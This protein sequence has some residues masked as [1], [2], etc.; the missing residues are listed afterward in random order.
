MKTHKIFAVIAVVCLS[1]RAFAIEGLTISIPAT[2]VVLSW[3]SDPSETYIIQYRHTLDTTD[4]WA[5][6]ADYYPADNSTNITFFM[7]T[8]IDFGV[9][10]SGGSSG[11]S[12]MFSSM[13]SSSSEALTWEQILA[14]LMPPTLTGRN[15]TSRQNF[16]DSPVPMDAG[17]GGD[18][19]SGITGTGFYRVVRDGVHIFGLTNGAVVSGTL[20]FPIE[21]ALGST[22][23]IAGVVF[24]DNN[25]TPITGATANGDGNYWTLNWET[26]KTFNGSYNIYAEIDFASDSPAVSVPISVT[27][28]NIISFPNYFSQIFGSQMWVYAKTIPDAAYQLDIYDENSNYLGTFSDYA[29]SGGYISFTWD[30][31]DGN[32]YTFENTNFAGVFTVDTSFLSSQLNKPNTPSPNG[33]GSSSA[34]ATNKWAKEPSWSPT[35]NWAIAYSPLNPSD[36][37]STLRISEMMVG[38]DGGAYGGVVS[39]IGNHGL[40]A[41]M[42]PG[43]VSQSSAFV[44]NDTNSRAQF[45]GYMAQGQYRNLYFFGHGS[46]SGFGTTGS[47]IRNYDIQKALGNYMHSGK[48]ALHHPYR[49]VFIDGCSAGSGNLCESFGIPALTVTTNY[50]AT[51]G[52]E[53]RAF[54]GFKT[55]TTFNPNQWT[56]RSLMLAGFFNN[57]LAPAG[58]TLQ[59]CVYNAQN[60][61]FQPMD[62]SAVIFG[63]A[64]LTRTT[65]TP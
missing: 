49:L 58:N 65:H 41:A 43:N 13:Q 8:N 33:G 20:Q 10:G 55:T 63:S 30:L 28:S 40:G 16:S 62:S 50:F 47:V 51:L 17:S 61:Q 54:L 25:N 52:V 57:W 46:P 45:L 53:S 3:P 59:D 48:P 44:M 14:M 23:E 34:S 42:S 64:N 15:L 24:Y 21:F 39:T 22:D 31:T 11:G 7:D 4:T 18:S 36:T 12:M 6:L 1:I 29:D 56:W 60:V 27:V 26:E 38:G 9:A 37:V 5:T 19:S 32:G 2:N 35:A